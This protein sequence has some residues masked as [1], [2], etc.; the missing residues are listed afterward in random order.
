MAERDP[1]PVEVW[2]DDCG[3]VPV[4][5][6]EAEVHSSLDGSLLLFAFRCPR[7]AQLASGSCEPTI[8]RLRAG[9]AVER[10]LLPMPHGPI[11]EA[12]IAAFCRDLDRRGPWTELPGTG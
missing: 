8:A 6:T 3:P 4:N 10:R 11:D 5:A 12:E 2:C 9:G 1:M 7:C